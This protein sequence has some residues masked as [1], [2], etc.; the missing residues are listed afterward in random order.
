MI[1]DSKWNE[2]KEIIPSKKVKVD[3]PEWVDWNTEGSENPTDTLKR[4]V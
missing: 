3:R 4:E 2:I 1:P